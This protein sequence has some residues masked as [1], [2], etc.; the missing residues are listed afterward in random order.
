MGKSSSL[1]LSCASPSGSI[2]MSHLPRVVETADAPVDTGQLFVRCKS[3]KPLSYWVS[4]ERNNGANRSGGPE[5]APEPRLKNLYTWV[6]L[7]TSSFRSKMGFPTL[8]YHSAHFFSVFSREE[9]ALWVLLAWC[10]AL[11]WKKIMFKRKPR[12]SCLSSG[13]SMG[14]VWL[15]DT[16]ECFMKLW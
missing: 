12:L 11:L 5:I 15:L 16:S 7:E 10:S 2:W 1:L 4:G 3:I 14:H 9:V 6:E 8:G 13:P